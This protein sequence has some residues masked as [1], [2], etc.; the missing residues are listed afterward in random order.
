M[1]VAVADEQVQDWLMTE[2]RVLMRMVAT[3]VGTEGLAALVAKSP[4]FFT[5]ISITT[6]KPCDFIGFVGGGGR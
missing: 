5:R 1:L 2:D 6:A 3:A 4:I